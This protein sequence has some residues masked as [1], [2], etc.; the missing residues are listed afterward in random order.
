MT[1]TNTSKEKN[2]GTPEKNHIIIY[3]FTDLVLEL[4]Y[5]HEPVLEQLRKFYGEKLRIRYVMAGLVRD[6]SDFITADE[7][8]QPQEE[9]I[10]KYNQRL[11]GIYLDEIPVGESSDEHGKLSFVRSR[12]PVILPAGYCI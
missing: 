1:E 11:A 5:E 3:V 12:A 6:I 2:K 9:G 7:R 10:K 4:S 8:V